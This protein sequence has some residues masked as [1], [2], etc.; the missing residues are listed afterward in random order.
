MVLKGSPGTSMCRGAEKVKQRDP[1]IE[2]TREC[3]SHK[4]L[5]R[6]SSPPHTERKSAE[7][8]S[9]RSCVAVKLALETIVGST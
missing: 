3:E 2:G 9:P 1:K 4:N 7:I 8:K 5:H 6:G